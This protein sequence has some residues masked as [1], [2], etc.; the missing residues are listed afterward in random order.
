M[1]KHS[2]YLFYNKKTNEAIYAGL[3]QNPVRRKYSHKHRCN[4]PGTHGYNYELYQY[5]RA[6]GGFENF[7]MVVMSTHRTRSAGLKKERELMKEWNTFCN[8][9]N[10]KRNKRG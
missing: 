3:T 8:V 6:N 10:N 1:A 9:A 2:A 5:I 7:D 4:T